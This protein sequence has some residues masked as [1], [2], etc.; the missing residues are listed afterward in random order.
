MKHSAFLLALV[1]AAAAV[2]VGKAPFR[3]QR[4]PAGNKGLL[5]LVIPYSLIVE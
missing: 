2:A 3:S 5:Q 4:S 1:C